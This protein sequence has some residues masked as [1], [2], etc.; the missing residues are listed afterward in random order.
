MFETE[1]YN[2]EPIVDPPARFAS[3]A[4]IE[5]AEALRRRLEDRYLA[6]S[7]PPPAGSRERD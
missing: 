4:E 6:H 1:Q 5:L 7:T 2:D 3:D